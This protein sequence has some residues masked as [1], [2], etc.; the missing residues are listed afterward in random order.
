MKPPVE[1]PASS[2][3]RPSTGDRERVERAEQLVRAAGDPAAAGRGR[4][5][6]RPGSP[7]STPV[8]GLVAAWPGDGDPALGDERDGVLAGAGQ[9]APHEL[10]VE[11]AAAGHQ[12][13]SIV[14]SS[15]CEPVVLGLE[16]RDVLGDRPLGEVGERVLP[17]RRRAGRAGAGTAASPGRG[18]G[19][20]GPGT[21]R[22]GLG[23]VI[24]LASP[25]W[26][27]GRGGAGRDV[28]LVARLP[29]ARLPAAGAT[30][31]VAATRGR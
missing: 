23:S 25:L 20:G 8:A 24:V 30:G 29:A 19:R 12:S 31:T 3:R 13:W 6:R 21:G 16:D 27:G 15:R 28:L 1:A 2:A 9:A 5:G 26:S 17:R 11:P 22:G 4:C 14:P 18:P 10:R 7:A